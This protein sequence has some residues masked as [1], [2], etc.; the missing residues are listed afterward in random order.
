MNENIDKVYS[1][2]D[3]ADK[4]SFGELINVF[5]KEHRIAVFIVAFLIIAAIILTFQGIPYE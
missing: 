1:D 2:N 3:P 4:A 5:I